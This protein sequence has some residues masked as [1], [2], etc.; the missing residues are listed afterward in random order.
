MSPCLLAL[1]SSTDALAVAACVGDDQRHWHGPGG[2]QASTMLLPQARALLEALGVELGRVQAIAW[3][4]GPGAFTGL[5]SAGA[6]AQ[7]L[8]LGLGVPV[9]SLDSLLLVAEAARVRL[10]PM[11]ASFEIGVAVDAR[12]GEVYA[13]RY[14]CEPD[15]GGPGCVP[16][17]AWQTVDEPAL[18]SPADVAAAWA[19]RPPTWAVGS[20]LALWPGPLA[21]PHVTLDE[22]DR[23]AALLRLT[24]AA[25][26]AGQGTDPQAALPVYVRDR[27]A[28]TTAE[29]AAAAVVRTAAAAPGAPR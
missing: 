12:M 10:G 5:R 2:A 1:D 9:L 19:A 25:W 26:A 23:A 21:V 7:G 18:C 6:V 3:G 16:W 4:R 11:S 14:R 17:R 24:R 27:V 13:G 8:A 29:R 22:T 20:G 15:A 28:L